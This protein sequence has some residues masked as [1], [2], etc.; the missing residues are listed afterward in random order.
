M[1]DPKVESVVASS[2]MPG[3]KPI[4]ATAPDAATVVL[5]Y[6][7]RLG[8]RGSR[9]STC[10]RSCRSTSSRAAYKAGTFAAGLDHGDGAIGDR[11]HRSIRAARVQAG[12]APRLRSQPD[13]LAH[14]RRRSEAAV[15]RSPRAAVHSRA[16]RG[17]AGAAGG[18]DR[19][20]AERAA[21]RRLRAGSPRRRRRQAE[22]DRGRCRTRCRRALVLHEAGDQEGRSP[23]GIRAEARVP[24]GALARGRS[25]RVRADGVPRRGGSG[26]GTD[27]AGQQA[28]VLTERPAL[29]ARCH[30]RARA[31]EEHRPRGSQRQRRRR[32]RR[33]CRGAIHG[34]D[35]ARATPA[36]N[37]ASPSSESRRRRSASRST[38]RRWNIRR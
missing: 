23:A 2:V 17:A 8:H 11:R 10:S 26:L 3:G 16:E 25:R 38:P 4:Q 34:D 27:H 28:V 6:A 15:S 21:R 5:T 36:T 1:Y 22:I 20:H 18:H 30:S 7:Q 14:R 29:S 12:R 9:C 19:S 24:S 32:N 35:A 37:A 13:L 33:R 31:A